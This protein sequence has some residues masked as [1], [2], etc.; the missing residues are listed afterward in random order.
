MSAPITRETMFKRRSKKSAD[1]PEVDNAFKSDCVQSRQVALD[2]AWTR[3]PQPT[4]APTPV[5]PS[6]VD[7]NDDDPDAPVFDHRM[8]RN[9]TV[10]RSGRYKSKT[11]RRPAINQPTSAVEDPISRSAGLQVG[12]G[13]T[14]GSYGAVVTGATTSITP[15]AYRGLTTAL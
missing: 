13:S 10:S 2:N 7:E 3:A 11:K 6:T 12:I 4:T 1:V 15:S 8:Q 14:G 5:A 9:L